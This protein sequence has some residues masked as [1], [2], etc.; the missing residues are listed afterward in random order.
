[1]FDVFPIFFSCFV[2][3]FFATSVYPRGQ[4]NV[5]LFNIQ[6]NVIPILAFALRFFAELHRLSSERT[7]PSACAPNT[8]R[9]EIGAQ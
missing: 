9:N 4:I 3:T 5:R 6:S 2:T 8:E 1:M 7:P